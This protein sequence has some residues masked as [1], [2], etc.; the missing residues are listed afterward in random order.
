MDISLKE[1]A[2]RQIKTKIIALAYKPNDI[3]S[4][5]SLLKDLDMSRTPVRESLIKLEQEGFIRIIPKRGILIAPLTLSNVNRIFETRLLVEP[6]LLTT[7]HRYI[8]KEAMSLLRARFKDTDPSDSQAYNQLDDQFHKL[9]CLN[10]PNEFLNNTLEHVYD[11]HNRVRVLCGPNMA[12]RYEQAT[13]EHLQ[14]IETILDGRI[15]DAGDLLTKHLHSSKALAVAAL[16]DS[17]L[18]C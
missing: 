5:A 17:D 2:Y 9:I 6:F 10:S 7:Y 8:D 4:E 3:I 15:E 18:S 14:L 1:Q 12:A 13:R 11:Q 16:M